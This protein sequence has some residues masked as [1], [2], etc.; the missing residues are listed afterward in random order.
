M[1]LALS[2]QN[3]LTEGWRCLVLSL[4]V[5]SGHLVLQA[6]PTLSFNRDIRPI[7]SAY[8]LECHGPDGQQRKGGGKQGLRLDTLQGATEDLGGVSA[9]IPGDADASLMI[10]RILTKDADDR[11]PP[12]EHGKSLSLDQVESLKTWINQGANYEGHWAY[13]PLTRPS[14]PARESLGSE[15]T[16]QSRH[17]IDLF[18]VR[19][20]ST[21]Q[22]NLTDRADPYLLARRVALDLTGLPPTVAEVDAFVSDQRPDAFGHYVD[23]LL[24]KP[25]YGEHWA[26]WWLDQARY[27]DSAGYADDPP[28]TIWGYRDYVIRSFNAN[29]PFDQFTI[30]QLAGDLLNHPSMDQL[31]ATAFHRNT[32]TNNEGG[33]SD[34]EF[35]NVAVVDRV[36]TTWAVWMGTTMACA[37]CHHHKYDPISQE[38]YFRFFDLMNQTQDADRRDENPRVELFTESQLDQKTLLQKRQ[39]HLRS[40]LETMTQELQ[41]AFEAWESS[42]GPPVV[43]E[44]LSSWETRLAD[45]S[46]SQEPTALENG[47]WRL[48]GSSTP[49]SAT[50]QSKTKSVSFK[51]MTALRWSL[52]HEGASKSPAQEWAFSTP[53]LYWTP[54]Q[55]QVLP[56]RYLRISLPGKQRMLSLAEVQ[57]FKQDQNLAPGSQVKQSSTDF[58]GAAERAIDG[59]TDGDYHASKS[60]THTSQS[61]DPWWELDLGRSEAVDRIVIWNRTDGGLYSRLDGAT[62]EWMD[63]NRQVLWQHVWKEAP[64]VSVDLSVD[65]RKQIPLAG[66]ILS[67]RDPSTGRLIRLES[68]G[69]KSE[70]W[71]GSLPPTQVMNLDLVFEEPLLPEDGGELLLQWEQLQWSQEVSWQAELQRSE[72]DRLVTLARLSPDLWSI[73]HLP[74]ED[75]SE[76]QNKH[77][78]SYYLSIAPALA[79]DRDKLQRVEASLASIKPYTSVPVMRAL[80]PDQQRTTRVQ[81]R[82][83][84]M[85]LGDTVEAGI[86]SIFEA[87]LDQPPRDRLALA[88]WLVS[89]K[90]PLTARVMVN[91]LWEAVFGQGLVLTSEEFGS[92]G[93]LPTHPEL[94]DWLAVEFVDSDWDIKHMLR[95]MVTSEAY[96]QSSISSDPGYEEDPA[97]RW[98]G[99]GQRVRLSAESIRDQALFVSGLLSEKILGPSVNPPQPKMGLNAAFGSQIDWK[100]S[101]GEDRYRRGL[102]TTWRRSNPYP[103]MA[104]FDAPNREVCI[105]K[106][107]RSNTPLQALVT[108][109]DPAF[110]EAAQ[111]LARRMQLAQ[112]ALLDKMTF[113]WRECLIRP[114]TLAELQSME[115]LYQEALGYY[116]N[117]ENQAIQMAEDPIGPSPEGVPV[118]ELASM[119]LVANALLNLD[120]FLMKP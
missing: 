86:P 72:D 83:N 52:Q 37:Q 93:D 73:L 63:E 39:S 80:A 74:K 36:N 110:V 47:A 107:D 102:Y 65:G 119:V 2:D 67:Y 30:E 87:S 79:E 24:R 21:L 97:N 1:K 117:E 12:I 70:P 49:Y 25:S 13:Q 29:M 26:R 81:R 95:L 64:R 14:I 116:R 82:G 57:C 40:S 51:P 71:K 99:R 90:N 111:G 10:Q 104:V 58:G 85:D 43:W 46:S 106:R 31:V 84:F 61:D 45:H 120:E 33:T 34:E 48:P 118:A 22:Q 9:V 27:A 62:I 17:P 91:R 11:M 18:I 32:M 75:R 112:G 101:E 23:Q 76:E 54:P 15:P 16:H 113:G 35:R 69:K 5:S 19:A 41:E 59:L 6:D 115:R 109:N 20:L 98:L 89:N 7:L 53:S 108:L 60:V 88:R 38:D 100:T 56:G 4:W 96:C 3:C 42:L 94:L 78:A 8:C 55:G 50:W 28:R 66:A 114:P 77:L 44:R 105:L 103:S 68:K 92:Q